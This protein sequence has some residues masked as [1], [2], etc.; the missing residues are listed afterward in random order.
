MIRIELGPK[1]KKCACDILLGW[2]GGIVFHLSS[3]IKL[4][5]SVGAEVFLDF[6]VCILGGATKS[7]AVL[8][9]THA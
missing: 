6:L 4:E 1:I 3:E 8:G 9:V 7:S 5:F 2:V